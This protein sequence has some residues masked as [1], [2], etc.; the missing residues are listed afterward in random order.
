MTKVKVE[1]VLKHAGKK[2]GETYEVASPAKAAAL[3]AIGLAKPAN[4][5][6]AR[7]IEKVAQE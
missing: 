4:V 5:T 6:A 3:E 2:A 7:K 1:A